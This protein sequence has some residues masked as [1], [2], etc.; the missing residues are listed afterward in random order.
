MSDELARLRREIMI[1]N[2][3]D[4][5]TRADFAKNRRLL[6]RIHELEEQEESK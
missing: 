1:H 2:M 6:D 5:W 3:K 4:G